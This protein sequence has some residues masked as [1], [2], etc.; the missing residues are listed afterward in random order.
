MQV[1]RGALDL[2]EAD[3]EATRRL[4]D[5]VRRRGELGVRVWV[6]PKHVAFGRRDRR[7]SGYERARSA[8]VA[9]GY[10]TTERATGGRAIAFHD[11]VLAV[12]RAEPADPTAPAVDTRY[13]RLLRTLE[14]AL[15]E[16]G[17]DA[18]RGEP[19]ESFCP[20]TRSLSAGGKVAGLAQRVRREVAVVAAV[21]VVA[22]ADDLSA[23]LSPVYE[24]LGVPFDPGSVGSLSAAGGPSASD[25][26]R[27][28]VEAALVGD[29]DATVRET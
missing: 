3:A 26:V 12:V 18:E 28:T 13:Q 8:A 21:I 11:G 14:A 24:A 7:E 5:R 9:R 2:P 25:A 19:P 29:T 10:P 6:P 16:L 23:V 27:A 4:V 20:G 1:L 22:D 17:V 15:D